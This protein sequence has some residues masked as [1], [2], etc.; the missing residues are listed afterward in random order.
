[1]FQNELTCLAILSKQAS[2]HGPAVIKFTIL[3]KLFKIYVAV[4]LNTLCLSKIHN[5]IMMLQ[6]AMILVRELVTAP[7]M[8]VILQ[9]QMYIKKILKYSNREKEQLKGN[10][11]LLPLRKCDS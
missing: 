3:Q 7:V 6:N 11:E 2:R 4:A 1:M 5:Q 10:E 9:M 8:E